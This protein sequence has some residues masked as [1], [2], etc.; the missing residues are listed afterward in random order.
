MISN[1]LIRDVRSGIP[2]RTL[3]TFGERLKWPNSVHW[4]R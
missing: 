4:T 2:M 1:F 3:A